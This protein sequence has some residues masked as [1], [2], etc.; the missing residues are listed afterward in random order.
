VRL[1]QGP[2]RHRHVLEAEEPARVAEALGAQ[3]LEQHVAR[4]VVAPRNICTVNAV[5]LVLDP[6]RAASESHLQP[7]AAHLVKHADFLGEAQRMVEARHV[8]HRSEAQPARTLRDRREIH[9]RRR[10]ESER[11][12]VMFGDVVGVEIE[13]I[14]R[15]DQLQARGVVLGLR[16]A[17]VVD[18]IEHTE[19]HTRPPGC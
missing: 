10:R 16:P 2:H 11:C 5:Q 9:A 7:A 18:V 14:E 6:D 17:A 12:T 19:F 1:L 13:G 15:L 3:R 8:H 4:L